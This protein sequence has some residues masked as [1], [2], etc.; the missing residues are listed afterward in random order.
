[1]KAYIKA[2]LVV[3]LSFSL[4]G[5]TRF[6]P[7]G[8]A[9]GG[10]ALADDNTWTGEQTFTGGI[11]A[12]PAGTANEVYGSGAGASLQSGGINNV[13]VGNG[14][15][16]LLTTGDNNVYLG[17][18]AGNVS[19]TG[20][21]NVIIGGGAD[22]SASGTGTTTAVGGSAIGGPSAVAI[23]YASNADQ[24]DCIAIGRQ[25]DCVAANTLVFG[26]PGHGIT[27][28]YFGES[29]TDN[30]PA[31]VTLHATGGSGTNTAGADMSLAAGKGTGSGAPGAVKIQTSATLASGTTLQTLQDRVLIEGAARTLTESSATAVVEV[32]VAQGDH[33]GGVIH[34]TVVADDSTNFQA[35]SGSTTF[36][37]VNPT[38]TE[39]CT[40]ETTGGA[41][42]AASSGTLTNTVTCTVGLT[43]VVQLA[44]NAAS[45]LTQTTLEAYYTVV[46]NGP[47]T[48]TPQ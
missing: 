14:A 25:A 39:V 36:Q 47:G 1:M 8:G 38:G 10:V 4:M 19:A 42:E 13:L 18:D 7:Q 15:G 12:I 16:D 41:S 28:A 33:T 3:L 11:S 32:A 20:G 46:L 37:A 24:T 27:S 9:G 35:L 30:S 26:G 29:V 43:D 45:S 2:F 40:V 23:G 22:V 48:L 6:P 5:Q 44:F 21:L 34:W 17:M 31:A